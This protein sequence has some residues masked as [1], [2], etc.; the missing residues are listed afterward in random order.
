MKSLYSGIGCSIFG[1]QILA[2]AFWMY[3]QPHTC[4]TQISLLSS[5]SSLGDTIGQVI[6]KH[7]FVDDYP[8][9]VHFDIEITGLIHQSNNSAEEWLT[10][11]LPLVSGLLFPMSRRLRKGDPQCLHISQSFCMDSSQSVKS[12]QSICCLTIHYEPRVSP[13]YY[14]CALDLFLAKETCHPV[15]HST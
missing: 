9:K 4:H 13:E 8:V 10:P 15:R 3:I 12:Q 7:T 5:G 6:T 1:D 2:V 11:T 14:R